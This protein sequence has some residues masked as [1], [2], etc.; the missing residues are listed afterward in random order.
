MKK[1]AGVWYRNGCIGNKDTLERMALKPFVDIPCCMNIWNS[2]GFVGAQCSVH[3]QRETTIED[4]QVKSR[5]LILGDIR[6][7]NRQDLSSKLEYKKFCNDE[8][9]V[10]EAYR[11]WG[12]ECIKYLIGDFAAII[13]DRHK[14][15]VICLRDIMGIRRMYYY[16]SKDLFVFGSDLKQVL[17]HPSV[18]KDLDEEVLCE[19]MQLTV[20]DP[21]RTCFKEVSLVMKGSVLELEKNNRKRSTVIDDIPYDPVR[22]KRTKDYSDRFLEIFTEAIHDRVD[23]QNVGYHVSGGLDSSSIVCVVA[24]TVSDCG[25]IQVF[26][27]VYPSY[28]SVDERGYLSDL[29]THTFGEKKICVHRLDCDEE[30]P[31]KGNWST[32]FD[33]DSPYITPM[34]MSFDNSFGAMKSK[35]LD[36]II[37]GDPGDTIMTGRWIAYKDLVER[38]RYLRIGNEIMLGAERKS[39]LSTLSQGDYPKRSVILRPWIHEDFVRRASYVERYREML[40]LREAILPMCHSK[41]AWECYLRAK[42]L[43]H[44]IIFMPAMEKIANSRGMEVRYPYNDSRVVNFMLKLPPGMK[45]AFGDRRAF[46]RQTMKRILPNSI[47]ERTDKAFIDDILHAGLFHF[48]KEKVKNLIE[49]S[50][51]IK[52]TL[53]DDK[54]ISLEYE[55]LKKYRT[56]GTDL[57]NFYAFLSAE[58]WFRSLIGH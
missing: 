42:S 9:L 39:V 6:I 29:E 18:P 35:N 36:C 17:C 11:K 30:W 28:P 56:N 20:I 26:S 21:E 4:H 52:E 43:T 33:E 5:Y 51:L 58:I 48:E 55:R 19:R 37:T 8:A 45:M 27:N 7:D 47:R 10:L 57:V 13:W 3:S 41:E 24:N 25:Q 44:E 40:N 22:Y 2:G 23:R 31:L 54:K 50:L 46:H 12:S 32:N 1:I 49:N 16:Y 38:R 34:Q 15:Q 14:Q 53:V